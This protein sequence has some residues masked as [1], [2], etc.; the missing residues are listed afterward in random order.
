MSYYQHHLFFCTNDRQSGRACCQQHDA[1]NLRDYAKKRTKQLGI[2]GK[3]GCVR[4]NTA[5]CL[6]RCDEG[7]VCVVYPQGTWYTYASKEDIDEIIDEHLVNNRIVERLK[8]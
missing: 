5:G 8:L 1:Q 3:Q 6:N 7:P 4:V 2:A